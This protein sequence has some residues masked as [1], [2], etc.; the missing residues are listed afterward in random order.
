MLLTVIK[1]LIQGQKKK[2]KVLNSLIFIIAM[3]AEEL[4]FQFAKQKCCC[5]IK[6][7][8]PEIHT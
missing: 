4:I 7:S 5:E 3:F 2:Q 6:P 8:N 1:N